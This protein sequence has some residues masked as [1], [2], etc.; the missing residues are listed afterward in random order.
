MVRLNPSL[1][2]H[3]QQPPQY[4]HQ[5]R[6]EWFGCMFAVLGTPLADNWQSP[7]K[8]LTQS[9]PEGK[10]LP[11]LANVP[12]SGLLTWPSPPGEGAAARDK[13]SMQLDQ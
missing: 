12:I 7:A 10:Q 8:V 9:N 4:L 6:D 5:G 13:Q 2:W 11:E 1:S 3:T